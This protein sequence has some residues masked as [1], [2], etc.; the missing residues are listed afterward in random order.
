MLNLKNT[1][2]KFNIF[3][4]EGLKKSKKKN[5]EFQKYYFQ[6]Q[7]FSNRMFKENQIEKCWI[8]KILF[9]NVIFF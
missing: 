9:S 2:F 3:L 1:I 8:P 7:H 6:I 5:L 4:I